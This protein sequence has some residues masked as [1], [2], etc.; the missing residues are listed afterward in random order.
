MVLVFAL[1]PPVLKAMQDVYPL[2]EP[3]SSNWRLVTD[4][5][6]GGRSSGRLTPDTADG[7]PC[8]RMRGEVRLDNNGGFV[9]AALDLAGDEIGDIT[10][11]S[12]FVL[13]LYGN[14]Q[15]YNMHLRTSDLWLPWQA[16]RASFHVPRSWISLRLP[17]SG[18]KSYRTGKDLDLEKLR[19]IGLVAIGREFEANLCIGKIGLYR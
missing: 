14:D 10:A 8:L 15:Q 18:F 19:R 3:G 2:V 1:L 11:Y 17:F 4:Q 6:M 5:V 9:Q 12:G 16:Y 7:R 13:E